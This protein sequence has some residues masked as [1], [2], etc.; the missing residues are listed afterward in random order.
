MLLGPAAGAS[1][2]GIEGALEPAREQAVLFQLQYEESLWEMSE[3][4]GTQ[5]ERRWSANNLK[6]PQTDVVPLKDPT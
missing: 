3:V 6:R 2:A 5:G 4:P 1:A